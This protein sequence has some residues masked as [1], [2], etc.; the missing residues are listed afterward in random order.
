M[1]GSGP[2]GSAPL[3]ALPDMEVDVSQPSAEFLAIAPFG[4]KLKLLSLTRDGE[5]RFLDDVQNLHEI[6]YSPGF[7]I[8][9]EPVHQTVR[10]LRYDTARP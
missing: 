2:I 10:A 6:L 3:G 8:P 4:R 9:P 1:L 7:R 5:Y